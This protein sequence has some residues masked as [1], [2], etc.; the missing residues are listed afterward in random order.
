MVLEGSATLADTLMRLRTSVALIAILAGIVWAADVAHGTWV[1]DVAKSK[2]PNPTRSA[3]L[4]ITID[5]AT[6]TSETRITTPEGKVIT[7]KAT[8]IRDGNEH[9]YTG[10]GG[11][12]AST[13]DAYIARVIDDRL[14]ITEFKKDGKTV[15]TA[16][17]SYSKDGDTRAVTITGTDTQGRAYEQR[18]VFDRQ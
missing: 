15:R 16:R 7:T 6:E 2:L 9:A 17:T 11:G 3:T 14:G 1:L 12:N 10:G 8:F 5:G 13:Y 4:T 18:M